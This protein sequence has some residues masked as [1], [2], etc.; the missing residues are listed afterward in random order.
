MNKE[1]QFTTDKKAVEIR[2]EQFY[3]TEQLGPKQ[4][5]T[6][7]GFLLCEDVPLA[8]PGEMIYGPDETPIEADGHDVVRITR[9]ADELFRPETIASFNGKPVTNDHPPEDVTPENWSRYAKGVLINVR[10]GTGDNEGLLVGDLIV[11]DPETIRDIRNDKREVSLGYD[12]D[13]RKTGPGRGEQS[14][15]LGNHVALVERGRCGPRCAIHDHD[16]LTD[17]EATM[18]GAIKS[19]VSVRRT[20][21]SAHV[22][23]VLDN[24]M[25]EMERLEGGEQTTLSKDEAGEYGTNLTGEGLSHIHIHL[26][27]STAPAGKTGAITTGGEGDTQDNYPTGPEFPEDPNAGNDPNRMG[28]NDNPMEMRLQAL[29]AA[30]QSI[31]QHLQGAGAGAPQAAPMGHGEPDGDEPGS[32][33]QAPGNSPRAPEQDADIGEEEAEEVAEEVNDAMHGNMPPMTKDAARKVRDSAPLEGSFRMLAADAEILIPG[34]RVPTF[35]S[36]MHP[37]DTIQAMCNLRKKALDLAYM[38][39]DGKST[40]D[41][42]LRGRSFDSHTMDCKCLKKTFDA[43]VAIRRAVNNAPAFRTADGAGIA[44]AHHSPNGFQVVGAVTSV[45]ELNALHKQHYAR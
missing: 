37:V 10:K 13:Y 7:E 19:A 35:D 26:E 4:S 31:L 11:H 21:S 44:R 8:R 6:P 14:L 40:I 39:Q 28:V 12:A 45:E 24:A 34:F 5:M 41:Q 33:A 30:I 29:E 9:T 15:I 1:R 2:Q 3:T 22:R 42:V 23:R 18:P 36:A 17:K 27:G 20:L 38:T 43:A 32:A 25:L 16:T